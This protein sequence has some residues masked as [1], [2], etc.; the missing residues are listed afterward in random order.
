MSAI[1]T[2]TYALTMGAN[3]QGFSL[4]IQRFIQILKRRLNAFLINNMV[5]FLISFRLISSPK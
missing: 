4:F 1:I 5:Q 2:L 3:W